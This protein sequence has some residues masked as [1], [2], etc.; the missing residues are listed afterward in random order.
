MFAKFMRRFI[1]VANKQT[2]KLRVIPL[3]GV[4][5]I[6]KNMTAIE[7]GE[8]I[9]II[10]CGSIFPKEDMYGIDLVIPDFSYL[11]RNRDKVKAFLITHGHEDH[12]GALPYVLK[13]IDAPIYCTSLT[14]ALI[15]YKFKEHKINGAVINTIHPKDK[16]RIGKFEVEFIKTNHSIAGAVALAIHTP[17]G[18]IVHTGDFKV[19]FTPVDGEPIDLAKFAELGSKGVLLLMA[20]ST[21][22]EREGFTMSERSV[23]RALE[24]FFDESEDRRI[25]VATFASN[26]HRIQQIV[27]LAAARGRKVCFLG[28]SMENVASIAMDIGEMNV[29]EGMLI[30]PERL[31]KV[32][33]EEMVVITT[34]S[35][36]EPMSGLARMASNDHTK[37]KLCQRDTVIIS[38]SA[39][40]GN[41]LM[42]SR[43]IN[44][45]F[46]KG[47]IVI[48]EALYEVHVSGHACKGEL[49][50]IHSLTKPKYF[51][52]VHGE[53]RHLVQHAM[54]A[55]SMGMPEENIFIPE[56]G[57]ALEITRRSAHMTGGIP[58][59]SLLIDGLGI[60][61]VGNIVMRDRRLLS[62]DGLMVVCV[63]FDSKTGEL[64]SGPD[65][66]SR[67]FVYVRESDQLIEEAKKVVL[68][69]ISGCEPSRH[70]DWGLIKN[71]LRSKLKDFLYTKTK[72]TPMILP[73]LIEV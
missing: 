70:S 14:R 1:L 59:G 28:R 17:M 22:V 6:G 41:E 60:G 63:T 71:G 57:N 5:E 29:P 31:E 8:D 21:N 58:A 18:V 38:A 49:K 34:G 25:I 73:I 52:P 43:V 24:R 66:I 20:D 37:I 30:E 44:N 32:P 68:D 51:M 10:D 62:Q 61:D 23:G 56:L 69:Y 46:R 3:G 2:K 33:Y 19:D 40:P 4:D 13:R 26:I 64:I 48:Y 12:I 39:I 15:E 47:V 65:I 27:D 53:Y 45:L 16:V 35:Q 42:V 7:Y 9:V 55:A 11:E 36:G 67:G 54:L 72:R 50:L